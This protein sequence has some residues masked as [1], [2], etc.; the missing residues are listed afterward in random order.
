MHLRSSQGSVKAFQ[1]QASGSLSSGVLSH[2]SLRLCAGGGQGSWV[3]QF[4]QHKTWTQ[5]PV[6]GRWNM[7]MCLRIR[8]G[9]EGPALG[10]GTRISF[11]ILPE[12]HLPNV[13][14]PR[15]AV[16]IDDVGPAVFPALLSFTGVLEGESRQ[17]DL[18]PVGPEFPRELGV[19]P[20]LTVQQRP[21][22]D[23]GSRCHQSWR[24]RHF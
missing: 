10:N 20:T 1:P 7:H 18:A 5:C 19:R 8:S 24:C 23:F 21:S 16:A 6:W 2:R 14:V 17:G 3:T 15:P 11:V 13:I 22:P 4:C 9:G 12:E